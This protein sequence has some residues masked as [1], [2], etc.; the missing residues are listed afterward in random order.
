MN[1]KPPAPPHSYAA[2]DGRR[3]RPASSPAL[4]GDPRRRARHH[5][6]GARRRDRQRRAADH[7]PQPARQPPPTR[8]GSSTP[9]S[10]PSRSRCCRS[11]RSATASATGASTWPA[12]ILFTSRRSAARC[13][14]RCRRSTV[15]RV[16]QGFGAAGIMSV[17]TALVRMIYP[18][19]AARPRRRHQR[20]G[21]GDLV[22]SRADG[23]VRRA[24]GRAV[25]VAVRDQRADRHRR[26]RRRLARAAAHARPSSSRT[27]T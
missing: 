21:G 23:R 1:T 10:S 3:T 13:R 25:A 7:R 4:L 22:G 5:A 14:A 16:I 12:S 20:H 17:N 27:T 6:R 8:S 9:I 24:R 15:A 11:P 2:L 18:P 19:D 26:A